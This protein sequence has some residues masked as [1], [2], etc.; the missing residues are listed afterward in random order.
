MH[1]WGAHRTHAWSTLP[2]L[3]NSLR[4][5]LSLPAAGSL[6]EPAQTGCCRAGAEH[7]PLPRRFPTSFPYKVAGGR[8]GGS[9]DLPSPPAAGP[10]LRVPAGGGRDRVQELAPP[11]APPVPAAAAAGG[12][13]VRPPA[14]PWYLAPG[15]RTTW[16]K[17]VWLSP[18]EWAG[19]P[20]ADRQLSRCP[21]CQSPLPGCPPAAA[22]GWN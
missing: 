19:G 8:S 5:S 21:L 16:R 13:A 10:R 20:D 7:A 12:G 2:P 17:G 1:L 11:G 3:I 22:S 14:S 15:T 18:G 9:R 4:P 6:A